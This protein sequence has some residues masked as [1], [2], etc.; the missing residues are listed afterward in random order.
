MHAWR[1]LGKPVI[2]P[3]HRQQFHEK[4]RKKASFFFKVNFIDKNRPYA[5]KIDR[6]LT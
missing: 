4:K 5:G 3:H 2:R 6:F 1:R